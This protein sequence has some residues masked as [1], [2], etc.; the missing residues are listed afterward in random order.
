MI[1]ILPSEIVPSSRPLSASIASLFNNGIV[2]IWVDPND[3]ETILTGTGYAVPAT[4]EQTAD[5]VL[6]KS[7]GLAKSNNLFNGTLCSQITF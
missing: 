2:G 5:I 4:V 6:D 7:M 1:G 3:P